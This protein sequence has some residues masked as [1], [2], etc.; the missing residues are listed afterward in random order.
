MKELVIIKNKVMDITN[1]GW[2]PTQCDKR[3]V[4][5]IGK[6]KLKH[7]D[8]YFDKEGNLFEIDDLANQYNLPLLSKELWDIIRRD[9]QYVF[10]H[11]DR[12]FTQRSKFL[13]QYLKE[14]NNEEQNIK[15][16]A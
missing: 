11:S 13:K 15:G 9:Y 14:K 16:R 10:V 2:N 12:V 4:D 8:F 1:M 7:S 5:F 3:V 6:I